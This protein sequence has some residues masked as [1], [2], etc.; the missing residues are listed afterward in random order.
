MSD[1]GS[2]SESRNGF[3]DWSSFQ[4]CY[5][6]VQMIITVIVYYC[7]VGIHKLVSSMSCVCALKVDACPSKS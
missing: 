3:P 7:T 2:D 4:L 6:S 1:S 5:I